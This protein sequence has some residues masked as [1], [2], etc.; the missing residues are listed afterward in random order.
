MNLLVVQLLMTKLLLPLRDMVK[1]IPILVL[2]TPHWASSTAE[3]PIGLR[4]L[5]NGGILV[6]AMSLRTHITTRTPRTRKY[7]AQGIL[8][9]N[10][11]IMNHRLVVTGDCLL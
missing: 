7:L 8:C 1:H 6:L 5:A 9:L 11:S 4:D 3:Q 10:G 2:V